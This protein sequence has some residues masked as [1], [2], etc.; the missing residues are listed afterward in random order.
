[1]QAW[2]GTSFG[3]TD[4]SGAPVGGDVVWSIVPQT[5]AQFEPSTA[6]FMVNYRVHDLPALVRALR[7][8]GCQVLEKADDAEYGQFAW[9][10]DPE[11]NKVELWE[12][13]AGS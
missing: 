10:I 1:M 3:A 7:E 11:G 6:A 5:S 13:H 8:E 9:V 2:G 12:P 4:E